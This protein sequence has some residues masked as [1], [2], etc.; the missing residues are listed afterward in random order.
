MSKVCITSKKEGFRRCGIPHSTEP[1]TYPEGRWSEEEIE[2][3]MAE[4][5]LTVTFVASEEEAPEQGADHQEA[6]IAAM[7]TL[8]E[9]NESLWTKDGK[10][11][12]DANGAKY[13]RRRPG[14]R[15]GTL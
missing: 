10:P 6:I 7:L 8:D 12:T 5:M 14:C 11:T 15:L 2:T 3:L 4:P 9:G 13:Q 1:T